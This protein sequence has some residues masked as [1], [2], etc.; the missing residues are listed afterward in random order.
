MARPDRFNF[1]DTSHTSPSRGLGTFQVDP[2]A[3][4]EG[5]VRDSV[6]HALKTGYRHIDTALGYGWGAVEREVGLAVKER[7]IPREEI[8]IVTKLWGPQVK[9]RRNNRLKLLQPGTIPFINQKMFRLKNLGM[10]YG[11]IYSRF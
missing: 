8:S 11:A 10:E 4:P 5:S 1:K 9:H 6:S 7:Q 2:K 3:Y